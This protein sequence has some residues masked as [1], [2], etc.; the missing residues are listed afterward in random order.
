MTTT[1]QQ[2]CPLEDVSLISSLPKVGLQYDRLA[3]ARASGCPVI[4]SRFHNMFV[5]TRY[6]DA[7]FVMEHPELFSSRDPNIYGPLPVRLPPL[8]SDPPLQQDFRKL[9]NPFFTRGYFAKFEPDMRRIAATAIDGW[10]D[11]GHCEFA[12]EFAIPFAGGVL[13]QL[14]F[15]ETDADRLARAIGYV[16]AVAEEQTRES[17]ANLASLAGEY[18]VEQRESG[19]AGQNNILSALANGTVGGRPLTPEEQIGVITVLFLGGLDTTRGALGN[20]ATHL[21][22]DPGI[23]D[24]LRDPAWVR[25]DLEEFIR[26][27]SPVITMARTVLADVELGGR[28]LRA[29][30][31]IGL[32]FNSANRDEEKFD[33]PD[34]LRFDRPRA[35]HAGFGL[36][37]HRCIGMHL[38]RFQIAVGFEE[39]LAK[40]TRLRPRPGTRPELAPGVVLGPHT[41]HLEF[42]RR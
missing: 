14:V 31:R 34:E 38:A 8:D 13:A 2:S 18:L 23:E 9:L 28:Q 40:V 5:V 21:A 1:S 12:S 37:I 42:D 36:G 32:S 41:L 26:F 3:E 19:R 29:G 24:R 25:H 15:D 4:E 16:T 33:A 10:L 39:L 6:A 27:D 35:G 7:R 11:R 20:I 17:F 30:D 22:T